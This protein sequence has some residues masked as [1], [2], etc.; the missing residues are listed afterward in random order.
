MA[1][2][3]PVVNGTA[4]NVPSEVPVHIEPQPV[5]IVEDDKPFSW[6]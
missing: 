3:E 6:L 2:E 4:V 1:E 5:Q